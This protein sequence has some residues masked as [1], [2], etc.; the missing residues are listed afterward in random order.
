MVLY[1]YVNNNNNN[2][3]NFSEAKHNNINWLC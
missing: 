3:V 1:Y 2:F